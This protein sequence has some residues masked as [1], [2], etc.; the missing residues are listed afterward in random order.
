MMMPGGLL[1]FPDELLAGP[2]HEQEGPNLPPVQPRDIEGI[3]MS[4]FDDRN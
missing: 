4:G 3:G 1:P 2:L